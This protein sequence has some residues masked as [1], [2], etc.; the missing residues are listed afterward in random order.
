MAK[1]MT[2]NSNEGLQVPQA[3]SLPA[4]SEATADEATMT[5]KAAS[6]P[7]TPKPDVQKTKPVP[8]TNPSTVVEP[9]LAVLNAISEQVSDDWY[10]LEVLEKS[11]I[12][13]NYQ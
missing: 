1:P 6:M 2:L 7:P 12:T 13:S 11:H 4:A 3:E 5:A 10:L 8:G 9:S